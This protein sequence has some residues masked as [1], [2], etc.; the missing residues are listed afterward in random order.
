MLLPLRKLFSTA[1]AASVLPTDFA[2]KAA[3]KAEFFHLR[4]LLLNGPRKI[5]RLDFPFMNFSIF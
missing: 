2:A 1:I 5:S 4:L 3:A